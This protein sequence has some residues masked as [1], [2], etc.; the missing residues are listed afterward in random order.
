MHVRRLFIFAAA[1]AVVSAGGV[2]VAQAMP[3]QSHPSPR[4][5]LILKVGITETQEPVAL[6]A[7][8]ADLLAGKPGQ[9][10][11][12]LLQIFAVTSGGKRIGYAEFTDTALTEGQ[13]TTDAMYRLPGGT[14]AAHG[15]YSAGGFNTPY[16]FAVTG[17]TGRYRSVH[18]Q[19]TAVEQEEGAGTTTFDFR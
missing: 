4:D 14:I 5:S 12:Q 7:A 10:G 11:A 13:Y 17:G 18:G 15:V 1:T 8:G 9:P 2:G 19:A 6:N 16:V 3:T